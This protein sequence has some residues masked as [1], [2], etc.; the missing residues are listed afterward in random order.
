MKNL[1]PWL[2]AAGSGALLA[3]C[4]PPWGLDTLAWF[5][6]V[7]LIVAV[8]FGPRGGRWHAWRLFGLGYV[9]GLV[10]FWMSL[11]WITE[12][13][14]PGWFVFALYLA[15]FP[16]L[17]A[18]F[19][20]I[21]CRPRDPAGGSP[22]AI[23][24]NEWLRSFHNLRLAVRAAAAWAGI[25]WLRG[26]AFTGFGWNSF[27]VAMWKNTAILQIAEFTG[28]VGV[29]FL[30]VLVNVIVVMT[31][32]RFLYEA[33]GGVRMRPHFDFTL[34]MALIVV[35]F[36]FGIWRMTQKHETWLLSVAAV[37]A[38]IPQDHK[39]DPAFEDHIL[40][41]YLRLTGQALPLKPDLLI[42]PEAATPR[43]ML[44]DEHIKGEVIKILGQLRTNFLLGSIRF[45]GPDAFNSAI[46]LSHFSSSKTGKQGDGLQLYDKMHLVPFGEYVPLRHSFPLF[47]WLVGNQVPSDFAAGQEPV[48]MQLAN[49][50]YRIGPLICFEDTVGDLT[51]QFAKRGAELLVTLTNDGWF[52]KSAG[53]EQH[54]ANAVLRCAETKL[55]LVRAAN[56]GVTCFI[57]PYGRVTQKLEQRGNTFVEGV[58]YG[59]IPIRL[60][61]PKTFYT[62]Y[63]D[64]FAMLCFFGALLSIRTHLLTARRPGL[65][66]N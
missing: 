48:V 30:L 26:I 8:W 7:P 38:N 66:E 2:L 61:P 43:P 27:G 53:S 13:T 20:G 4:F 46:L 24:Q 58:L 11:F 28:V 54:L 31:V 65:S 64:L 5:A 21:L 37:Q 34:T 41:T 55:P 60:E 45:F 33:S 42:W 57:D 40:A 44:D 15:I 25:E 29:S 36:G 39:W 16:G 59:E 18:L 49:K 6:L 19:T 10:F 32:R 17:W 56:T 63:G 35:S 51:R 62:R 9:T 47:A 1:W 14:Q 50:P 3:L 12:V 52:R 22:A 23:Q